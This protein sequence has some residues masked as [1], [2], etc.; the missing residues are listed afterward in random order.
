MRGRHRR[1]DLEA[2]QAAATELAE[3]TGATVV[4]LEADTGSDDSVTSHGRR[5]GRGVSAGST[6]S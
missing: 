4:P 1:R 3:R 5:R 2:T 6:S